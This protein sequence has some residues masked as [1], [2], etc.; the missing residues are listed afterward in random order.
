[1]C[2]TNKRLM[3]LLYSSKNE[4]LGLVRFRHRKQMGVASE[5]SVGVLV[6]VSFFIEERVELFFCH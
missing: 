6:C 5:G 3:K 4:S 2:V 1:M